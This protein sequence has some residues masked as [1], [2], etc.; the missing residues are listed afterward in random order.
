MASRLVV[1]F[2]KKSMEMKLS[3][4]LI[5]LFGAISPALQAP[6]VH[7]QSVVGRWEVKLSLSGGGPTTVELVAQDK[8]KGS[9]RVLAGSP[10]QQTQA[11][12]ATWFQTTNDRVNFSGEIELKF[13]A[14]CTDTGTLI[15]KGKFKSA[16]SI[17]GKAIYVAT[18]E[19]EE[20]FTGYISTV[21]TFTATRMPDVK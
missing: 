18:T 8:G 16:D 12:P 17:T 6:A 15:L 21:G 7:N 4:L 3:L 5:V 1:C 20:N 2:A 14:C 9:F 10:E 11:A 13:S 19:N